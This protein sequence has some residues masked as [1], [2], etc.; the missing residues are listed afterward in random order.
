[1]ATP[2]IRPRSVA[3]WRERYGT[4]QVLALLL[5]VIF[6]AEA[7]WLIAHTP[8]GPSEIDAV[9]PGT[10]TGVAAPT[11]VSPLTRSVGAALVLASQSDEDN[12]KLAAR[13]P[14]ALFGALLGASLWYVARRLY[15]NAGGYIALLLY[16]FSPT[17][18]TYSARVGPEIAAA[19][20]VF[21]CIFT[22]IAVA[23]TLYAPREVVLWNW[24]RILLL[25][26]AIGM[27]VAA[28][29][30]AVIAIAIALGFMLYLVPERRGATLT[31]MGTAVA[32][33]FVLV[34]AFAG[35]HFTVLGQMAA[36]SRLHAFVPRALI[37]GSAWRMLGYFVLHN[38]PGFALLLILSMI[39]YIVWRHVRFFGATAPLL[40]AVLLIACAFGF[41]HAAGF[42]FLVVA[43]PFLFLFVAGICADLLQSRQA[44]L[45]QGMILAVLFV[46]AY[47]SIGG[48]IRLR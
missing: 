17:M 38:G 35:F 21:G 46:H 4:P 20:G 11:Q 24:K 47:F 10:P 29:F 48:L 2:A 3:S 19:W 15:G 8:F 40:T 7:A 41:P 36:Q 27:G 32:I 25:G 37:S 5:L 26:V 22:G 23:H 31:I 30:S 9:H 44:S 39:T 34:W 42:S 6:L 45:A 1:M 16:V 28:E 18:I 43:L 13:A 14:F 33:G 12:M